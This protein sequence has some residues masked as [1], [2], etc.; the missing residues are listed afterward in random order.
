MK[1]QAPVELGNRRELFWDDFMIDEATATLRQHQP[2]TRE[3]A[4]LCDAPWEGSACNYLCLFRDGPVIRLYYLASRFLLHDDTDI[5]AAP[6]VVCYAESRDDGRSFVK[7][8]LGLYEYN[9]SKRNNIIL[10][11]GG[12]TRTIDNFA[13]FKDTNPDC[14]LDERYKAV[15][16]NGRVLNVQVLDGRATIELLGTYRV[17]DVCDIPRVREQVRRTALQFPFVS[18]V[19]VVIN[20]G[21]L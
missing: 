13:V 14:P 15:A 16:E 3:I 10:K 21:R 17:E 6:V 12:Y 2:E 5:H 20:G 4:M 7:P 18:E 1:Q 19:I 11:I 8:D 9:G